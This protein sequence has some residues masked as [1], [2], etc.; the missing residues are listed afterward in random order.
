MQYQNFTCKLNMYI[1]HNYGRANMDLADSLGKSFVS[2]C[3]ATQSQPGLQHQKVYSSM[4]TLIVFH[5]W[6]HSL[7]HASTVFQWVQGYGYRKSNAIT[8]NS[9]D[10]RLDKLY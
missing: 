9:I 8:T 2:K 1:K 3:S 5:G 6:V 4:K 7:I 10:Q